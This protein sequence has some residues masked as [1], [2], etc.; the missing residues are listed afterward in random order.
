[1]QGRAAGGAEHRE[2][3]AV[4][5]AAESRGG[6]GARGRGR[7]RRPGQGAA[8]HGRRSRGAAAH[9]RGTAPGDRW[10]RA[11]G[12]KREKEEGGGD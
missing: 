1:M 2:Q 5:G 8:A 4:S 12:G 9:G 10:R 11:V 6:G 3:A 7:R